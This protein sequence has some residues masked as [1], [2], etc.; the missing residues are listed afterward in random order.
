MR[1]A[2]SQNFNLT[3]E[4]RVKRQTLHGFVTPERVL[5]ILKKK[6]QLET[7]EQVQPD[8]DDLQ[9]GAG[10]ISSVAN[11]P[12]IRIEVA[13]RSARTKARNRLVRRTGTAFRSTDGSPAIARCSGA[14]GLGR[15]P[16]RRCGTSPQTRRPA[17]KKGSDVTGSNRNR[18]LFTLMSS[19]LR[20]LR[21]KARTSFVN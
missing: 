6:Q 8:E 2:G 16:F 20:G 21:R 18:A 15:K 11:S 12:G 7:K 5:A 19:R 14:R 1:H 17:Q 4:F 10:D 9:E 3:R 13:R